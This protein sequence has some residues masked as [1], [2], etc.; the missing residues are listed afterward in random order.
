MT[1][2][3]YYELSLFVPVVVLLVVA[4]DFVFAGGPGPVE[5]AYRSSGFGMA[6]LVVPYLG[7]V[8]LARRRMRRVSEP[9]LVKLSLR[10]ALLFGG[11]AC[12]LVL[13]TLA[14]S[15][16]TGGASILQ[17]NV[18]KLLGLGAALVAAAECVLLADFV[19]LVC[20]LARLVRH[21]RPVG[22]LA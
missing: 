8:Y 1:I 15:A 14:G 10:A 7:L 9:E 21:E 3:R 13:A 11:L 17:A 19:L 16:F 18:G 22:W 2:R 6:L 4:A 20:Y 5:P 12:L